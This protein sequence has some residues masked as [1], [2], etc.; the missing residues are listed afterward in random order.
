MF[1]LLGDIAKGAGALIGT[2]TGTVIGV[3]ALVIAQTCF[4]LLDLKQSYNPL[5]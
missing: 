5:Y 1:D 3:P 4:I 2:V